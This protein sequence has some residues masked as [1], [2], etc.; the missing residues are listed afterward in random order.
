MAD[1]KLTALT[2]TV[3]PALTDLL[4]IV[5]DPSGTPASQ[6]VTVSSINSLLS[7]ASLADL[8]TGDPHTQYRLE[9]ADHTHQSTGLQAGQLDHGLAL[10]GLTDDDHT[11]YLL[12]SGTRALSADWDAGSFE[13]RAQTF[14]SDV[15]TGT[16]PLV[17]ASTTKVANL[18]ADL[19]DDQS[20]AF[21]LDSANFT[22]TNWTDLTDGGA[23]T[24]HSHAAGGGT[25]GGTIAADQVAFGT[26]LDT[27]GGSANLLYNS[28]GIGFYLETD[29]VSGAA[30]LVGFY[31]GIYPSAQTTTGNLYSFTSDFGPTNS[32]FNNA[33]NYT[34]QLVSGTGSTFNGTFGQYFS[35][36]D[37][38]NNT[39]NGNTANFWAET[40]TNTS[41]T[42][43]GTH[44]GIW[45]GEISAAPSANKYYLWADSDG[46]F[47]IRE[48][49]T[50]NS[51][52]QAIPALYNPQFTKYTPGATNYERIVLGQFNTNVAEIGTEAGGTGTLRPLRFLFPSSTASR[53]LALDSSK[54]LVNTITAANLGSSISDLASGIATWWATPSSANLRAALTDENGTGAA[55]FDAAADANLT[56][57]NIS[58]TPN[59]A[60]ERGYDATR[61]IPTSYDAWG[62]AIGIPRVPIVVHPDETLSNS[63]VS[64]Q[65][66]TSLGNIPAN[67]LIAQRV[68]RVT[69]VFRTVTD[70]GAS[71]QAAYLK[72]GTTKVV[73]H[74]AVTGGNNETRNSTIVYHIFGTAAAGASANVDSSVSG[75]HNWNVWVNQ[76]N[77]N[78]PVAL[79]TNGALA[80]VPG[81]TF[82]TSTNGESRTLLDAMVEILN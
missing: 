20:G 23:T 41:A 73:T 33:W 11:Q 21:Y 26:A 36:F 44:F 47:R 42:H 72:L 2:A 18:N 66:F 82:G 29:T 52:T 65:D 54:N 67:F 56:T 5:T 64:D 32:T 63:T 6:K 46:V 68:I 50:F 43:S 19:L 61:G 13:I 22:G 16:A 57:P 76:N 27:I 51:V 69:L 38:G 49:G 30:D 80:I 24:L 62:S 35:F 28:S 77:T 9:T 14:E 34:A 71:S 75:T 12:A 25:I 45:L 15:A 58:G 60:G 40:P 4:Y 70:G 79:A 3:S 8:T 48:D 7:H 78:Q 39:F 37:F 74:P 59:A 81:V 31:H 10:T 55:L 53:I 1:Q 17:I